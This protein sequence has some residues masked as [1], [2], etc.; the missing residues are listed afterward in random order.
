[1]AKAILVTSH[2]FH[3]CPDDADLTVFMAEHGHPIIPNKVGG[4]HL[5]PELQGAPLF[6]GVAGPMWGGDEHPLRYETWKANDI[7]SR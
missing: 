2:T 7:Y 4:K 6:D 1:M 5:M 3:I